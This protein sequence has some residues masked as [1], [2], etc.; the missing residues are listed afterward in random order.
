MRQASRIG[1]TLCP[2]GLWCTTF[3]RSK[4]HGYPFEILSDHDV[5]GPSLWVTIHN[6]GLHPVDIPEEL[7]E[8]VFLTIE[9]PDE[10][11]Y[12]A[13][14]SKI[15]KPY[16][17]LSRGQIAQVSVPFF[18]WVADMNDQEDV[19]IGT[20]RYYATFLGARSRTEEVIIH[21]QAFVLSSPNSPD[22]EIVITPYYDKL[23]IHGLKYDELVEACAAA[24]KKPFEGHP[25]DVLIS[26]YEFIHWPIPL[27]DG[28]IEEGLMKVEKSFPL[29][30]FAHVTLRERQ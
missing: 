10:R 18:A 4:R 30:D 13:T 22:E 2:Y 20:Y 23:P 19:P 29:R 27:H 12:I 5:V 6:A 9:T 26:A 11:R 16:R 25:R 15:D 8:Y 7:A 14:P 1:Q 3:N 21:R 17:S 24:L 28:R